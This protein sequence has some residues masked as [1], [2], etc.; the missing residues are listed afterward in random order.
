MTV[1][2]HPS[3]HLALTVFLKKI[4]GEYVAI[5]PYGFHSFF[6]SIE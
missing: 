1:I 5:S 2:L 3:Q 4:L 6:S